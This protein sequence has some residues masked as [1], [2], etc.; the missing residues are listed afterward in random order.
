MRF[1]EGLCGKPLNDVRFS[2]ED[3]LDYCAEREELEGRGG[4]F[5]HCGVVAEGRLLWDREMSRSSSV[6][7]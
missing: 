3:G 1:I 7:Y 6:N 2:D 4:W 5:G